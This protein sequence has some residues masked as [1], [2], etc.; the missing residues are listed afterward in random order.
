MFDT[1]LNKQNS[2]EIKVQAL[3]LDHDVSIDMHQIQK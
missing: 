2:L 3:E 1:T